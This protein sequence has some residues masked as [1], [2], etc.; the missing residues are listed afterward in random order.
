VQALRDYQRTAVRDIKSHWSRGKRSVLLVLPTGSGKTTVFAHLAGSTV[1]RVLFLCP[2]RELV[3]Q[4]IERLEEHNVTC[5]SLLDGR[6]DKG[7]T[8]AV[9][10][11]VATAA[12]RELGDFRF[13][14]V[15]EAHRAAANQCREILKK[16]PRARILGLTATPVRMDG[17][18][19]G[20][21]FD[22]LVEPVTTAELIN[23]KT[24][25]QPVLY[26]PQTPL[27]LESVRIDPKTKD[28]A[29]RALG[30]R[31][32]K[33]KIMG[34]A[35]RHWEK[36]A[37]NLRTVAYCTTLQHAD[38]YVEELRKRGANVEVI[39]GSTCNTKRKEL[40][41]ALISR[42]LN[43]LVNVGVLTEG[44]DIPE[45]E[46]QQL[47]RPTKSLGLAIQ[48][49]G[50][51]LRMAPGKTS[52]LYLDHADNFRRHGWPQDIR[53]WSLTKKEKPPNLNP[54]K[55]PVIQ[56]QCPRCKSLVPAG[57]AQC[58]KCEHPFLPM[59]ALG[60]LVPVKWQPAHMRK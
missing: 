41:A 33:P 45:I 39:K 49:C 56:V 59:A 7:H 55:P 3:R 11:T 14:C 13:I 18:K 46:C 6:K 15:D 36:H 32:M 60:D 30:N 53:K 29:P 22:E 54:K 43:V 42:D 5:Q 48:I 50:R 40:F 51:G 19:L 12:K 26:A 25:A 37:R 27:N 1:G 57:S 38:A 8:D 44:I 28:Y 35:V 21:I 31:M 9:V 58:P 23:R 20:T 34:D 16:Y 17:R 52:C 4:G 10:T 2:W 24:L 47:L